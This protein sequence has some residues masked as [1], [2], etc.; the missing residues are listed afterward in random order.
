MK[1][2]GKYKVLEATLITIP[3]PSKGVIVVGSTTQ[4]PTTPYAIVSQ[5][6]PIRVHHDQQKKQ[7]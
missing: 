2:S 4:T 5:M 7:S 6:Q 1:A 3:A